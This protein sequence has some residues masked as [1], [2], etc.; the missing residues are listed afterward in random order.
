MP[1]LNLPTETLLSI[2][3]GLILDCIEC[4]SVAFEEPWNAIEALSLVCR[5]WK[6]L[7]DRITSPLYKLP[8]IGARW[9]PSLNIVRGTADTAML[10]LH[11]R[12]SRR[13]DFTPHRFHSP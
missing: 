11:V 1:Q 12:H 3:E 13:A 2:L 10:Q 4:V 5:E 8:V 9:E 6:E 7:A